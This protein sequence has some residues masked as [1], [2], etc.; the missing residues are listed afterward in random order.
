MPKRVLAIGAHPDDIEFVMAGTLLRLRDAGAELHYMH[1]SSGSCGSVDI[2]SNELIPIRRGESERA[3]EWLGAEYHPSLTHDI[4]IFYSDILIRRLTAVIRTIGPD[5]VLAP[6]P[7]DY[8]V[9]HE[10]TARLVA[11]AAFCRGIPNYRTEPVSEPVY[12]DVAIYHAMPYGLEGPMS[13][14][15][16]PDFVV[17]ISGFETDRAKL[18]EF[19]A[20]QRDWL[21]SS[22]GLGS[23]VDTM[24]EMSSLV[25]RRFELGGS[26]ERHAERL[27]ERHAERHAEGF[28]RRSHRGY[29]NPDF[30]P[31]EDE[32]GQ[33]VRTRAS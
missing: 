24:L 20:S 8:M 17:D 15:I 6:S 31:L 9:D 29:S 23:Y 26:V 32:I 21:D 10:N 5:I 28:R 25:A 3:A 14:E 27:A 16:V 13:E 19:H 33:F 12:S 22:Q 11:T 2:A 18:L 30:A 1:L 7:V 4:E